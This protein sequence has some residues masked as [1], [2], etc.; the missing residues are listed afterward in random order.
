VVSAEV[1]TVGN[2]ARDEFFITYHGEP[3]TTPMVTLVTNALQYYLSLSECWCLP[4]ACLFAA[5]PSDYCYRCPQG[6]AHFLQC[7]SQASS[8]ASPISLCDTPPHNASVCRV[9]P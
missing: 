9:A 1:D 4:L 7:M 5:N 2:E 6:T 8:V 3:L